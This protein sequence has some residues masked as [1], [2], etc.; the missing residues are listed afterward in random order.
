MSASRQ[1][2]LNNGSSAFLSEFVMVRRLLSRRTMRT[3]LSTLYGQNW[4]VLHAAYDG[5]GYKYVY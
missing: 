5:S 4:R 3:T 1:N 2:A